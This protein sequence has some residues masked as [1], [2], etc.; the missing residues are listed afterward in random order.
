MTT[1]T[2]TTCAYVPSSPFPP[3][4]AAARINVRR[5]ARVFVYA[6]REYTLA[7]VASEQSAGLSTG[8]QDALRMA[9]TLCQQECENLT[10]M[11][12]SVVIDL[13][14]QT[15][16][17]ELET[18]RVRLHPGRDPM[19]HYIAESNAFL[20]KRIADIDE[21]EARCAVVQALDNLSRPSKYVDTK[22]F[23]PEIRAWIRKI[24]GDA[25]PPRITRFSLAEAAIVAPDRV[26]LAWDV[27][28]DGVCRGE[29]VGAGGLIRRGYPR[30]WFYFPTE[31]S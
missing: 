9:V 19:G 11:A 29:I 13:A 1:E 18:G 30:F 10:L 24:V 17:H 14:Q 12:P 22:T 28:D 20:Q 21:L 2:T 3:N 15:F 26:H 4:V 6:V 23:A 8:D 16:Q 25:M 5:F 27:D 31:A 7:R